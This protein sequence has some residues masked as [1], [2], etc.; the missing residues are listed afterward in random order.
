M[1]IQTRMAPWGTFVFG[2]IFPTL[3]AILLS[4][5]SIYFIIIP[6]FEKSFLDGKRDMIQELTYVVWSIVAQYEKEEQE[7]RLSREEAQ[8]KAI[9]EI[10]HLRY[11]Q[12][13]KDYFWISDL[14][15]RLV[16]HPY[17]K[18][19]VG[20]DLSQYKDAGGK[21]LFLEINS[22]TK[23]NGEGF[24]DYTWKK[25][26][27]DQYDVSKLSYVKRFDPWGWVVG[28]G[29]Y[30]DD[31]QLKT[32]QITSRLT[33]MI[34]GTVG[35]FT[36]LLLY[37][38]Y[39]SLTIERRRRKVED[40]LQLSRRK[41]KALAETTTDPLM[42]IYEGRCI[43]SNKSM[44]ALLGYSNAELEQLNPLNIFSKKVSIDDDRVLFHPHSFS[45]LTMGPHETVLEKKDG[46]LTDEIVLHISQRQLGTQTATV[47]SVPERSGR[48]EVEEEL[49][50][51]KE[52]YTLLTQQLN[53]AVFR[54]TG[55]GKY[56]F[57]EANQAAM[58]LFG[59]QDNEELLRSNL[60]D[61][62]VESHAIPELKQALD[63]EGVVKNTL[64]N[65]KDKKNTVHI[66][67]L[68]M[69]LTRGKYEQPVFCD[70][71]I[72]DISKQKRKERQRENLIVELQTSLLFLNQPIRYSLKKLVTCD[73]SVPI[74]RAAHIMKKANS[75]AILVKTPM[76]EHVGIVTDMVLRDRVIA[77][78]LSY[79]TPVYEVMSSPLIY[80]QDTA[81]I[82]EAVLLMQEEG[83]KHL[84]VKNAAGKVLSVIDNEE[85]LH[86]H[87]YSATFLINE[88][89]D[90]SEAD[91][92]FGIQER[93][94]R[95]IKAL[96]DSGAHA[97]NITRII[98]TISDAILN[99]LIEFTIAEIG[100]P[101][102][103]F[104]FISL[105]SEGRGEQ[106]LATDQDNAIIFEDVSQEN[107]DAVKQY[108]FNFSTM[109]C[110]WLD[111]S[112]YDF[113]KG[114]VMAMNPEWCQPI[115]TWK[116]Y[117]TGWINDASPQDLMEVSIFFDFRCLYGD[118]SLVQRLRGHITK[119]VENRDAFFH[120]M[121]EN[122]LLFRLP[123][124]F[125]GNISVESGGEH[126]N[127]F[128]IKHII[129]LIV[130]YARIYSIHH[131]LKSTNTLERLNVLLERGLISKELHDEMVEAYDFLMQIRFK[132]QL[133][134]IE[135]GHQPDNHIYLSELSYMESTVMKKVVS[136]VGSVQKKLHTVGK[137]DI[138]F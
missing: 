65:L 90:A 110:T 48:K 4:I 11:G 35:A 30:L 137:S 122:A 105:G 81:L 104:A 64:F 37:V 27:T 129:A 121:A 60:V 92:L 109:V 3:I 45:D 103:R 7:N 80:V 26:D 41:Y 66:V 100:E 116:E 54:T 130:G 70:G 47:L 53:I 58:E 133:L 89:K 98:T 76:G 10:E 40:D 28:T 67:A 101:P 117:F 95:I 68:S 42:M 69:V 131:S 99:R 62:L 61:F 20:R 132:H 73:L 24:I 63:G 22:V 113:C 43:Y 6:A 8:K 23:E 128:N 87:R 13:Y 71:I 83:I 97:K 56:R 57:L 17:S 38:T 138:F 93:V 34:L 123:V 108:F 96:I 82:F 120:Q 5:L 33:S 124:D 86:I 74:R 88:I 79:D 115:S 114:K 112:G 85:L 9:E 46:Q 94:P 125:F 15:P 12:N 21:K 2:I 127:T 29:V 49:D 14:K 134:R 102:V 36:L 51:S 19:L 118:D 75:S 50:N 18:E 78:D 119:R 32:E 25:R 39:H 1:V 84:V 72:E 136:Q 16:M 91:E 111:E 55:E 107:F 126:P 106:T 135:E 59:I 77:N 44:E 31:V 52:R